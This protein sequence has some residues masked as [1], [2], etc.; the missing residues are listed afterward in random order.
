M[1]ITKYK[2]AF[3]HTF[4]KDKI[5]FR[6]SAHLKYLYTSIIKQTR[7]IPIAN[8]SIFQANAWMYVVSVK[9]AL[10]DRPR[11]SSQKT[12]VLS[13]YVCQFSPCNIHLAIILHAHY[14]K[15]TSITK[16]RSLFLFLPLLLSFQSHVPFWYSSQS[17]Y[18]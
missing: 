2:H 1:C 16:F 3:T 17:N 4:I 18:L 13:I 15:H 14:L 6:L 10:I 11:Q 7:S 8:P 12:M 5:L 9:L